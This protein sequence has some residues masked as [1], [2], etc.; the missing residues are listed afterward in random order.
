MPIT[1]AGILKTACVVVINTAATAPEICVENG[2][3]VYFKCGV[4]TTYYISCCCC[5]IFVR[6]LNKLVSSLLYKFRY[7]FNIYIQY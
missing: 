7:G 1:P 6:I 4:A 5:C 2:N 3:F